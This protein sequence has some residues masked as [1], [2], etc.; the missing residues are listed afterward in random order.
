MVP[1][2]AFIKESTFVKNNRVTATYD[3]GEVLAQGLILQQAQICLNGDKADLSIAD[4]WR[5]GGKMGG[6]ITTALLFISLLLMFG[7][8][9]LM[10]GHF[11]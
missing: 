6:A 2:P 5:I 7:A 4:P 1:F 3:D 9:G 10:F 8:F 11:D